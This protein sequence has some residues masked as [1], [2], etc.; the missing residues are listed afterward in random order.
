IEGVIAYGERLRAPGLWMMQGPGYDQYSTPGLVAAGATVVGFTT[1]RGTT[2]GNAVAPVFKI[3]SNTACFEQMRED[4]DVNAGT[5]VDGTEK[6]GDVGRRIYREIVR[7]AG[8]GGVCAEQWR[9]C[10]FQIWL[11][12]A[13]SL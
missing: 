9:H 10:E 2:I 1:G 7:I 3:A 11:E 12:Q 5:V 13:V 4:I 6:V 8:G